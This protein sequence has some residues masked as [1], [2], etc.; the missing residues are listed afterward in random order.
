MIITV[1]YGTILGDALAMVWYR[2]EA[3]PSWYDWSNIQKYLIFNYRLTLSI[4]DSSEG[5]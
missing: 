1:Y 4:M 5:L 2:N 3:I